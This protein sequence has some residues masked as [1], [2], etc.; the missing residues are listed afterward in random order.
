METLRIAWF[1][2]KCIKHPE[3]GGAE[4]FTHEVARRLAGKGHEVTLVTSRPKGLPAEEKIE[5]YKV[6]RAGGKYTV[7]LKARKIYMERIRGKADL[8]VDEINTLPFFTVKYAKEPVI[9]LIHQLAREYWL[10]EVKPPLSWIGYLLEPKY[11]SLYKNIPTITVSES[12]KRDLEELGFERTHIVPEGLNMKPLEK[13]P[14]KDSD[15]AI[16]FLGRL[17]KSKQ[18][19]HAVKAF[20]LVVEEVPDARL[21]IV[22]DGPLKSKLEKL[23][24]RLGLEK[25]VVLCGKVDEKEK[26][27][28]LTKAQVLVFPAVREGW[29]LV[30]TEANACGTPAVGYDVPGLRD[31][32]RHRETG[33]LVPSGDTEALAEALTSLL[34]D[35]RLREKLSKNALEWSKQ[36]SWDD[37]T[38]RFWKV[39]EDDAR[40]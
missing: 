30:V 22:G 4:V 13:F 37:T 19:D 9:A 39:L 32:I 15:P 40:I 11:L 27:K 36:F 20:K 28:L 8:I 38:E 21:W 1:N 31:S 6:L 14:E 33:I 10:I 18:P 7:Y 23:V 29:G 5:G 12:T 3:A 16:I 17:K 35:D 24:K 2:W 34:I 26:I 25:K